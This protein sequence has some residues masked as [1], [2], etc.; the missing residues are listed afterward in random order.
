MNSANNP[1]DREEKALLALISGALHQR[2]GVVSL[3]EIR[4]YL[5]D[6]IKLSAEDEAALVAC[7]NAKPAPVAKTTQIE[8][9][10]SEAFLALHRKRP[11]DGFSAKTEE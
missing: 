6:E 2:A 11:T 3:E 4:P 8:T 5:T 7:R 9:A 1:K 10:D